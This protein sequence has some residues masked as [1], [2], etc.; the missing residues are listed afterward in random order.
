M[1]QQ[2]IENNNTKIIPLLKESNVHLPLRGG[3]LQ[4]SK[5]YYNNSQDKGFLMP[6]TLI[7]TN[8]IF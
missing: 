6:P 8:S 1:E 7:Y 2:N 3:N 5:L 4:Q